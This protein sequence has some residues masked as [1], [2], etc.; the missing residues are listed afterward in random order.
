MNQTTTNHSTLM[1]INLL[2]TI[3]EQPALTDGEI[4]AHLRK[5]ADDETEFNVK[6]ISKAIQRVGQL[7]NFLIHLSYYQR[8]VDNH[9]MRF[10]RN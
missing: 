9:R 6:Q 10:N 2:S 8:R 1:A 3:L 5:I 7:G 4:I